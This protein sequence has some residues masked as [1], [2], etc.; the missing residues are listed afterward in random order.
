MTLRN[1]IR[2]L[3]ILTL[4]AADVALWATGERNAG[5]LLL[6]AALAGVFFTDRAIL[7]DPHGVG[8]LPDGVT[9]ADVKA[10]REQHGGS[11][12]DALRALSR[13]RE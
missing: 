1:T 13:P 3:G 10:H 11:I 4:G 6:L 9:A 5:T 8:R 2:V 12:S 7:G